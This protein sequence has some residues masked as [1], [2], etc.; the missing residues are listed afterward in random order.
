MKKKQDFSEN[1]S[2]EDRSWDLLAEMWD[3]QELNH[4]DCT[5][6]SEAQRQEMETF[7]FKYDTYNMKQIDQYMSTF[8]GGKRRK[9]LVRKFVQAAAVVLSVFCLSMGIAVA[10]SA[11]VRIQILKLLI[12][13]TPEYTSLQIGQEGESSVEVP[14]EWHGLFYP[15]LGPQGLVMLDSY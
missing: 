5:E 10:S 2:L 1:R 7:F 12:S 6:E 9:Q 14:S 15:T 11:N 4:G 8:H 3:M 13:I